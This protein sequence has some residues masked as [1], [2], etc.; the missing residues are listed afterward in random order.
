MTK[1]PQRAPW[2]GDLLVEVIS[3]RLLQNDLIMVQIVFRGQIT[4]W[5]EHCAGDLNSFTGILVLLGDFGE[6]CFS[7][8]CLGLPRG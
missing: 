1:C 6:S 5:P 7:L 4:C 8:L 2:A 3:G